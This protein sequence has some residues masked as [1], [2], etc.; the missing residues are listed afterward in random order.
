MFTGMFRGWHAPGYC[1]GLAARSMRSLGVNPTR[2]LSVDSHAF[3]G[4]G[5][6]DGRSSTDKTV[7]LVQPDRKLLFSETLSHRLH[8]RGEWPNGKLTIGSAD[9]PFTCS[10]MGYFGVFLGFF[11]LK[12]LRL[13]FPIVTTGVSPRLAVS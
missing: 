13:A 5:M 2:L 11:S 1:S 4:F 7:P 8:D 9:I 6:D 3:T 12:K 10:K